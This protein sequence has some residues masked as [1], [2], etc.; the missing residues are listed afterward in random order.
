MLLVQG[1]YSE[2]HCYKEIPKY[3]LVVILGEEGDVIQK[4]QTGDLKDFGCVWFTELGS[5]CLAAGQDGPLRS[6][7]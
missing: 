7:P 4:E 2:K 1:L 3:W 6:I 5:Q